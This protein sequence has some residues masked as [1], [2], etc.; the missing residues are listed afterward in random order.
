MFAVVLVVNFFLAPRDVSWISTDEDYL[1]EETWEPDL[2]YVPLADWAFFL[3]EN[4]TKQFFVSKS[5]LELISVVNDLMGEVDRQVHGS[6]SEDL[7]D[8][9]LA[10]DKILKIVHRFSTK[11]GLWTP[12][13]SFARKVDYD[14]LYFVLQDNS[15]NGLEGTVIVL[16][17]SSGADESNYSVWQINES[18]L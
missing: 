9:L 18:F 8:E 6:I 15:T 14:I 11:C 1:K 2:E 4:G 5:S 17:H 7:L 13:N 10:Q 16:E 3:C 12:P